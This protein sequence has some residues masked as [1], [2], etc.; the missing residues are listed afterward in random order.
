MGT[1]SR[2]KVSRDKN[3]YKVGSFS[4][5]SMQEYREFSKGLLNRNFWRGQTGFIILNTFYTDM[6]SQI[7]SST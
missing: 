3:D 7:A 6:V 2:Q 4:D 5:S 1:L